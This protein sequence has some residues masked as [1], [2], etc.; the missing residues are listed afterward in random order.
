MD[1]TGK[2]LIAMPGM[3]DPRFEHGVVFICAHGSEGAMGLIVNKPLPRPSFAE[4][5]EQLRLRPEAGAAGDMPAPAVLFGGPVETSRGFVLHSPDWSG[6]TA[7]MA[8]TPDLSMTATRDILDAMAEGRGPAQ[9]LLALGY[10]G[11]GPGQL[12]R[13][14]LDNGWL[15]T[16]GDAALTL[17]RDHA[18]KWARALR[19]IGVDPQTLSA[20]AGRA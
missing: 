6:Q 10:A 9:A 18:T 17:D 20:A 12:E 11:W 13:E 2:L 15:T 8:V 3:G 16:E 19:K 1:L 4:L 7:S 5:L 14:I